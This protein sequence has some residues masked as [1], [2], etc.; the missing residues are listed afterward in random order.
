MH[1]ESRLLVHTDQLRSLS[2]T[3]R[4]QIYCAALETKLQN[5]YQ[6]IYFY[7]IHQPTISRRDNKGF[8]FRFLAKYILWQIMNISDCVYPTASG[9]TGVAVICERELCIQSQHSCCRSRQHWDLHPGVRF[10]FPRRETGTGHQPDLSRTPSAGHQP[11]QGRIPSAGHQ[12]DFTRIP[13]SLAWVGDSGRWRQ[14]VTAVSL[15]RTTTAG[16]GGGR[17]NIW[18]LS[19]GKTGALVLTGA[20]RLGITGHQTDE[21]PC[22]RGW[23]FGFSWRS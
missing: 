17:H 21:T 12:P 20:G 2:L 22:L 9:C 10:P 23:S 14:S 6:L 16:G 7:R 8:C 15:I 5:L 3:S 13:G 11:N 18:S 1:F 19:A 4:Y